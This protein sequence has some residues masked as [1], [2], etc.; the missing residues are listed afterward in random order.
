MHDE[1]SKQTAA[2]AKKHKN[3]GARVTVLMIMVKRAEESSINIASIF[4]ISYIIYS[5]YVMDVF[6][7]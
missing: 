2:D 3:C 6:K 7:K 5:P 1:L 4:S